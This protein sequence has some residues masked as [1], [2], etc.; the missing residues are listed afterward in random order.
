[1]SET[2]EAQAVAYL[3]QQAQEPTPLAPG[4][5]YTVP[6]DDGGQRVIDTDQYADT[7]RRKTAHRYVSD[8][9]SFVNYL[10]K[11]ALPQTE[12]YADTPRSSVVAVIDSH[13]GAL[14]APGWQDHRVTLKLE[15]TKSWLAWT[16]N[17]GA[18]MSQS[19]FAE[20]IEQ[21]A[22]DVTAPAPGDLMTLASH[23]SMTIG[24]EYESS[25]RQSD[26]QTAL[27][28][29]EKIASKGLGNM[30]IPKELILA[31]Q[32]YVGGPR[33]YAHASFRTRL[34]GSQLRIGY[35]LVRPEEILE[36]TFADIVNEIRDGRKMATG[37][38]AFDGITAPIFNGRPQ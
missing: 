19:D 33:Q 1:M 15:H 5:V 4:T 27:V 22:T 23:M 12:V 36:G 2:T 24:V 18:M 37:K 38:N 7:P 13:A 35:V 11:H 32:P 6:A 26:G 25:Q 9:E 34:N 8:S 16:G 31:L 20:F 29:K 14:A 30:E 28:Y 21:R 10:A 17:D 3:A